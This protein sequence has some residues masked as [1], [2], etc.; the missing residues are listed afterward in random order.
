MSC[1]PI[2]IGGTIARVGHPP[3]YADDDGKI[4][5]SPGVTQQITSLRGSNGPRR[6]VKDKHGEKTA[7]EICDTRVSPSIFGALRTTVS[8]YYCRI[9]ISLSWYSDVNSRFLQGG[10][11][12]LRDDT[13][14]AQFFKRRQLE[15]CL[16]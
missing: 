4:L 9:S 3:I 11:K 15:K 12:V 2:H 8:S 6:A 16:D 5:E 1:W 14:D 10:S 13:I 7:T